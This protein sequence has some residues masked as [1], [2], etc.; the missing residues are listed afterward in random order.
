MTSPPPRNR[1]K[2]LFFVLLISAFLALGFAAARALPAAAESTAL[3]VQLPNVSLPPAAQTYY[4]APTGSDSNAGTQ[5]APWKTIQRGLNALGPDKMV[6]VR[7]GTY[8]EMAVANA[9]G[10]SASR[11]TLI[12]YPGERPVLAGRLKITAPYLRVSGFVFEPGS[13]SDTLVWIANTDVEL[14]SNELRNGTMSCVFGGGDR[15]RILSNWIHDCGTHLV[16]GVPQD[17]G[18]YYTGGNNG[19]I[20]NNVI[21]R[22]IGFGIQ[23][24]PYS[25]S[26]TGNVIRDNTITSN[27]RLVAG[28]QG[29]SGIILDGAATSN[30]LV[31]NNVL[32]WNSETGVRSLGTIGSGNVIRGNLGWENPK[33]N[34]PTGFY[35]GG[36]TYDS[37]S[38]AAPFTST[39]SRYGSVLIGGSVGTTTAG[40][41]TV[42]TTTTGP[43]T[44][45]TAVTTTAPK[46]TTTVTTAP[47]PPPPPPPTTTTTTTTTTTSP[48]TPEKTNN[49]KSSG[50]P[51]PKN[52]SILS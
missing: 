21:E 38:V 41:T 30:T 15:V 27:G 7:G 5:A 48:L 37:N 43:A 25:A 35:G 14:S 50:K 39:T 33:G 49:G 44:T 36:L 6:V 40:T 42:G 8:S 26:T 13:N 32:A 24:H 20:A 2:Q 51:P 47:T 28:S 52:R 9:G 31:E 1:R 3:S 17:H 18:V 4:V 45:S 29:A 23:V 19:L 12:A 34:F 46:T 16:N 11:A 10:S 22:A